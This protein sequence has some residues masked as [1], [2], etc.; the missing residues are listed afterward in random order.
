MISLGRM[1][2]DVTFISETGNDRVGK[3]ILDNMRANGVCTDNVN[4]FRMESRPCPGFPQ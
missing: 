3:M 2:V 4:V 1:G